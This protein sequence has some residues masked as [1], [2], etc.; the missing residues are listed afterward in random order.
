MVRGGGYL[1]KK[2]FICIDFHVY[3][4][5]FSPIMEALLQKDM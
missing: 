2:T 3:L 1:K 5:I 4:L